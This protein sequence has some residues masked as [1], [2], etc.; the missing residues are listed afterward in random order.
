MKK[1][2]DNR[3]RDDEEIYVKRGNRFVQASDQW[4][5]SGLRAGQ[6]LVEVREG[7]TTIRRPLWP[8]KLAMSAAMELARDAMTKAMSDAARL[9]PTSMPLSPKWRK[10]WKK[11]ENE[12]GAELVPT[13]LTGMSCWDIVGAGIKALTLRE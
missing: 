13:T 2:E 8:D 11:F 10:A 6:W 4:A 7:S 9:R 3:P 1:R 12:V 5:Y